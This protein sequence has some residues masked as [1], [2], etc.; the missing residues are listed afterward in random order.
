MREKRSLQVSGFS[1]ISLKHSQSFQIP[2]TITE[3]T[4]SILKEAILCFSKA[5]EGHGRSEF[6]VIRIAKDLVKGA[7]WM[8]ED[9]PCAFT[10]PA[11]QQRMVK[12]N[13]SSFKGRKCE[14]A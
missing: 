6:E 12:I 7:A 2:M 5:K 8:E 3:D 10:K 11:S 1:S 4:Q 9:E 14:S 13:P